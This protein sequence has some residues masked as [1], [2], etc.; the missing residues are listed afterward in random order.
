MT[1]A[2]IGMTIVNKTMDRSDLLDARS[3]VVATS[4]N[5]LIRALYSKILFMTSWYGTLPVE[6]ESTLEYRPAGGP[7]ISI[8]MRPEPKIVGADNRGL[9]Y[10]PLPGAADD[11]RIPWFLYWEICWTVRNGPKL[12][13]DIRVLD[14]GGTSSL[15]SCYLASQ[16]CEV[17]SVDLNPFLA[18]NAM[19]I[20]RSMDW[21]MTAHTMD[22]ASLGFDDGFFDHAYS[23]C[24]FEHLD[25]GK[26]QAALLEIARCLKSGGILS[27]TFDYRN[28]APVVVGVGPDRRPENHLS[29][30][31]DVRRNFLSTGLFECIGNG[32]FHDNGQ[33]YL[34][35]PQIGNQPYTFGSLFLRRNDQPVVRKV[36]N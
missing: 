4:I 9:E 15:M 3:S 11:G 24:V 36:K 19:Q 18:E 8:P 2:A 32:D 13:N 14:A 17:H 28:P 1:S 20:A 35:H 29:S 16:G 23:I 33:S 31:D 7:P 26:R 27:L 34:V 22:M 30:P 5:D 21:R 25:F 12:S 6:R 10:R